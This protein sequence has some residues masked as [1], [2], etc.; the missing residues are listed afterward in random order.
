MRPFR[1]C[2]NCGSELDQANS[3]SEVTCGS[4]G[5]TWY[6]NP[7]PTV[8]CVL[9]RDGKALISKRGGEPFKNRFDVPGGFL[10]PGEEAIEGL[11]REIKEE[12]GIEISTSIENCLQISPHRYG[13]EGE[14]TLAIG[15]KA[16]IVSGEPQPSDDVAAIEW[17]GS[18]EL[19]SVDFAWDHDRELVRKA[20]ADE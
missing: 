8:G 17:V 13:P 19:E 9:L 10:E 14:W 11:K 20:L 16:S 18:S 2:P 6:R 15:F 3:D 4:C 7:A 12:L 1:F 5:D